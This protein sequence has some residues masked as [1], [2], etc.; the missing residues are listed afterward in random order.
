MMLD[1][2]FGFPTHGSPAASRPVLAA[3]AV[4]EDFTIK[5]HAENSGLP[6]SFSCG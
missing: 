1:L 2:L 3:S 4:A 6:L 5:K